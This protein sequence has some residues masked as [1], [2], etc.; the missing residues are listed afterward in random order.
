MS[1]GT[2]VKTDEAAAAEAGTGSDDNGQAA[3]P[4]P[5]RA[6][7]TG[8]TPKVTYH[9]FGGMEAI[10]AVAEWLGS[11]DAPDGAVIDGE[12]I[13]KDELAQFDELLP[14]QM[15]DGDLMHLATESA[16]DRDQAVGQMLRDEDPTDRVRLVQLAHRAQV[17]LDFPTVPES[18]KKDVPVHW[19]AKPTFS[20]GG[21]R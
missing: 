10:M 5:R 16:T 1:A 2:A 18:Y 21:R 3:A 7:G 17:N 14:D 9:V 6:R 20:I 11:L 15:S 8:T 12:H 4:Q 19:E 13:T